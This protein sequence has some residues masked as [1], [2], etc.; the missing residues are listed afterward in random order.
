M[1]IRIPSHFPCLLAAALLVTAPAA[2]ATAPAR[3][4][5][6]GLAVTATT[7]RLTQLTR[8][9][10]A[11]G[12]IFPWQ[13]IIIAPEVGGYQVAA[14]NVEIGD[15]VKKGQVLARLS[16]ELL[17]SQVAISRASVEQA[18]AILANAQAALRRGE[19][20]STSGGLSGA[21]LDQLRSNGIAAQA[22]LS[23]ARANLD[24]AELRLRF[25]RVTAPD[26]GVI[27][28]RT[29]NIGQ[30]AQA[31]TEMLRLLR[32]QPHRMARRGAR[33]R[34]GAGPRRPEGRHHDRRRR[35]A[36]A[37][38]CAASRPP[39]RATTAPASSTST[40]TR[41]RAATR[42][43]ACS[44]AAR[45]RS[46][47]GRAL[48][49]PLASVVVQDGYSYVFVIKRQQHRRAP[50]RADRRHARGRRSRSTGGVGAG[51]TIVDQGA[52]FLKD[53]GRDPHGT[54]PRH[55]LRHL[56][57]PQSG[58]GDHDVRRPD[59]RRLIWA[60]RS[61]ASRTCPT[62]RFPTSSS[63]WATRAR[64]PRR[65]RPRSRARSRTRSPTSSASSTSP[66]TVDRRLVD[67]GHRVPV[68]HRPVAGDGRR[69]R[70][71]HAHPPRPAARRHRAEHLA[72]HHRRRRRSSP[73]ASSPTARRRHGAVV[74][75][76]P[77]RDA[78]EISARAR[79]RPGHA[80]SAAW[81][82]RSASTW[83]RTA[84]PRWA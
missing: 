64:R 43:P 47:T 25:T 14:V 13:E 36:S 45:S 54:R 74:V 79:R 38:R 37:A 41:R 2:P 26:D 12:S 78:R 18:T 27:T 81:R 63:R 69:A 23:T 77:Q 71:G 42:G 39:C 17:Q 10:V 33:G 30:I 83:T 1:P 22:G 11:T 57:D 82:A 73:S 50:P 6:T 84:W 44:R 75:R 49:V 20:L 55:E 19:S 16:S 46:A 76:R 62:S 28:A 40:S 7:P 58:P 56:V 34:P 31:G 72:R 68:R 70:C 65:W 8:R 51:E 53:G 5:N 35:Q 67:D 48:L 15:A 3:P 9:L 80:A 61:S 66:R 4:A 59:G 21:D 29:V 24:S 52:G 32:Q 60:S